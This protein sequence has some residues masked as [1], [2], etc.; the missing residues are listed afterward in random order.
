[1]I[2]IILLTLT[3]A[4]TILAMET[5]LDFTNDCKIELKGT[6]LQYEEVWVIAYK[7]SDPDD[8][9]NE[10]NITT[11]SD[12]SWFWLLVEPWDD[13]GFAVLKKESLDAEEWTTVTDECELVLEILSA[14]GIVLSF[15]S[16]MKTMNNIG[17]LQIEW[18][19]KLILIFI[20]GMRL[21]FAKNLTPV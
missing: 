16:M 20:F 21:T 13:T 18:F 12:C 6:E 11:D 8:T 3:L 10:S 19:M 1:M 4:L 14:L 15:I 2:W 17:F 9:L 7:C 5:S